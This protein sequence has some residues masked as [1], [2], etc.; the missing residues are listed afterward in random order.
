MEPRRWTLQGRR[1]L[2]TGGTR[3]IGRAVA[4][5]LARLGAGVTVVARD[6]ERLARR[7][8]GW[9]ED[10]LA[11]RGVAADLAGA[12]GR[13]AVAKAVL[14]A[15]SLHVL[16]NNVGTNLRRPAV[17]Y[18]EDEVARIFATNLDA[19]FYLTRACHPALVAAGDAAVVS[20]A[21]VAGL[22][23]L[24]TGVPYAMTKAA[25]VQMTRNLAVEW[26]S[27]GIRVNAVAPWYIDT[28][29]A[30]QVLEDAAYREAVLA[31]T[32]AG[33]IGEPGEVADVVAFLS[34]PAASYV[35]GQCL[36]V[37][38]GFM[39]SGFQVPGRP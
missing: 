18:R 4:E 5:T 22:T 17:D 13:A 23:H 19:A 3:G 39:A 16:V 29:L 38:G 31:A 30:R 8:S 2:V 15:G 12:E 11:I 21:S 14:E 20:V 10:G 26:A 6:G 27:D 28:P 37:D 25:L 9:R 1:A 34:M 35:T 24:C 32:P 7:L 36:A 33:R